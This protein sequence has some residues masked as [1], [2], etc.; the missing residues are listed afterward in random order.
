VL[1]AYLAAGGAPHGWLVPA[2]QGG[3]SAVRGRRRLPQHQY[4]RRA[5]AHERRPGPRAWPTWSAAPPATTRTRCRCAT[6]RRIIRDSSRRCARPNRWRCAPRWTA[7]WRGHHLADQRAGHDN[8]A[9][10]GYA[11]RGADLSPTPVRLRVIGI[12]CTPA[13]RARRPASR[14]VRAHHDRRRDPGRLRQ[15]G[16]AGIR[17]RTASRDRHH[18]AGT[19]RRATTAAPAKT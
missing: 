6:P 14:R 8:S 11:L 4:A 16:A 12:P 17:A 7:C 1:S 9:M 19:I 5:A 2:D 13:A 10:D 3:R 18:Q 15:R